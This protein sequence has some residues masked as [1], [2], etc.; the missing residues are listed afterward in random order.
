MIGGIKQAGKYKIDCRFNKQSIIEKIESIA[1]Y[2]QAI[3]VTP[4]DAVELIDTIEHNQ[5]TLCYFDPP[6]FNKGQSLYM[7]HYKPDDHLAVSKKIKSIK[8]APWVV[9]YDNAPEINEMY[10]DC[11]KLDCLFS[12]SAYSHKDGKENLFLSP[13]LS[14]GELFKTKAGNQQ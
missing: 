11:N 12:Y 7:N 2:A 9:S 1:K 8:D 4:L 6:Y 14:F 3:Y 10:K 13:G 5:N